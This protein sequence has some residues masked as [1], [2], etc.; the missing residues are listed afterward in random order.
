MHKVYN[1][2]LLLG[3]LCAGQGVLCAQ[4]AG[5]SLFRSQG[6]RVP[7]DFIMGADISSVIAL[8]KAGAK[9]YNSKGREEDLFKILA[10]NGINA[11]RARL[12]YD[13]QSPDGV[14]GGGDNGLP[15]ALAIAKRAKAQGMK[16]FLDFHYSDNWTHPGQQDLPYAWKGKSF[17]EIKKLLYQYTKSSLEA[18]AAQNTP[19]DGVQI[20]NEINTGMLFPHGRLEWDARKGRSFQRLSELIKEGVR[21]AR[22][23][24]PQALVIL[25]L[26]DGGSAEV[27]FEF[28]G[29]ME[30]YQVPYDMMGLSYYTF[31]HGSI[32]KLNT[33]AHQIVERFQKP[34]IL[35]EYSY[36]FTTE[37]TP[38]THNIFNQEMAAV[39]GYKAT[40]NGQSTLIKD[41]IN[42]IASLPNNLGKGVIYWE[43]A[44][45]P[46]AGVG[47]GGAGT[48]A[49][50]ANQALFDYRGRALP[51]LGVFKN[52]NTIN[53]GSA[54]AIKEIPKDLSYRINI[55][56][57]ETLPKTVRILMDSDAYRSLP[58]SWKN[59]DLLKTPGSHRVDGTLAY[60]G[61]E[62]PVSAKVLS[63][64]NFIVNPGFE[65]GRGEG[66]A[67]QDPA[68][69]WQIK[70]NNPESLRIQSKGAF[71]SG[72]SHL[73]YYSKTPMEFKLFQKVEGLSK[74]TYTLG[75]YLMGVMNN[76]KELYL[77]A[78]NGQIYK[79]EPQLRGW[80]NWVYLEIP[81]IPVS[82][83]SLEIGVRGLTL[84]E[85]WGHADD[86]ILKKTSE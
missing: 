41:S 43:P 75:V 58:L 51:S 16:V 10:D 69:P 17:D 76:I 50:W 11:V 18:F 80:G 2:A 19:V 55:Q 13:P 60:G 63:E 8:E 85:T 1:W 62:H 31:F 37:S 81:D 86:F 64:R 22:E 26:A 74:G 78:D 7:P 48:K 4:S 23:S 39:G 40:P 73:N 45:L 61:K 70:Q 46:V 54:E 77:Y 56:A 24:A 57:G 14:K 44:W 42:I 5:H 49:S 53:K 29:Q 65:S 15:T 36:A 34:L 21:A 6:Q 79:A 28:F 38:L 3:F 30:K 25:H 67:D 68:A 66:A 35:A 71:H 52:I 47:W 72:Y 9:Y 27:F 32:E 83:G 33:T 12:W 84:G 59:E 82:K 20:G